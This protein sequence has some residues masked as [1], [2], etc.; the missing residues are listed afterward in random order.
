MQLPGGVGGEGGGSGVRDMAP[1][2]L[3]NLKAKFSETSFLPFKTYLRKSAIFILRQQFKMCNSNN[4][5]PSSMF[6]LQNAWPRKKE[7]V[8]FHIMFKIIYSF[9][10]KNRIGLQLTYF[11]LVNPQA[12]AGGKKCYLIRRTLIIVGKCHEQSLLISVHNHLWW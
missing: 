4:F 1:L 6:S 5:T 9:L 8:L 10:Y 7:V 2:L 3:G 12:V 11:I